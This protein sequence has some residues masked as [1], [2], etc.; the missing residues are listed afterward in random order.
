MATEED[1]SVVFTPF[2][3]L[4]VVS[5][6]VIG[7]PLPAPSFRLCVPA[8]PTLPTS[9]AHA[10]AAGPLTAALSSYTTRAIRHSVYLCAQLPHT[11]SPFFSAA[12]IRP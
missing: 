12:T 7:F 9:R 8:H 4:G 11:T 1:Q 10:A 6:E 3:C 5:S 2:R